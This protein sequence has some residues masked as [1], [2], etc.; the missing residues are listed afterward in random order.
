MVQVC[1]LVFDQTA[2]SA[3]QYFLLSTIRTNRAIVQLAG[4]NKAQTRVNFALEGVIFALHSVQTEELTGL[5]AAH[6][7]NG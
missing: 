3:V 2:V 6:G 7:C 4:L 1:V 5:A